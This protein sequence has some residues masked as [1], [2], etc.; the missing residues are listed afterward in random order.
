LTTSWP[1]TLKS[2][3]YPSHTA[4]FHQYPQPFCLAVILTKTC[5]FTIPLSSEALLITTT[6]L[7]TLS[8]YPPLT[9]LLYH[10]P[11]P[12]QLIILI[13]MFYT[14]FSPTQPSISHPLGLNL[15]LIPPWSW[16]CT[17]LHSSPK[18][19]PPLTTYPPG[20]LNNP[21]PIYMR[22]CT[23]THT[24]GWL[25]REAGQIRGKGLWYEGDNI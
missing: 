25:W 3:T 15:D 10:S 22:A 18:P 14:I 19:L 4:S 5:I 12:S 23:H 7:T 24:V 2:L 11:L 1:S 17:L 8:I 20:P 13:K 21:H 9:S 16:N 6:Y